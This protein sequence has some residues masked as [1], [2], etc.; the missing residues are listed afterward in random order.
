MPSIKSSQASTVD[1]EEISDDWFNGEENIDDWIILNESPKKTPQGAR[2]DCIQAKTKASTTMKT[3]KSLAGFAA[4][5][6]SSGPTSI[7]TNDDF[8]AMRGARAQSFQ[9]KQRVQSACGHDV[10]IPHHYVSKLIPNNLN[11]YRLVPQALSPQETEYQYQQSCIRYEQSLQR[12]A[13]VEHHYLAHPPARAPF[14]QR[15]RWVV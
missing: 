11:C 15:G 5:W 9:E 3:G 7:T 14:R 8:D 2:K 13:H 12:H 10:A 4:S 6:M 1:C